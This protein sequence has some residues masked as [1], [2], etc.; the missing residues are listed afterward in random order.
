MG[1]I[2]SSDNKDLSKTLWVVHPDKI[3]DMIHQYIWWWNP[4]DS[5][6]SDDFDKHVVMTTVFARHF[7]VEAWRTRSDAKNHWRQEFE[8]LPEKWPS[9]SDIEQ[10]L[11][12]MVNSYPSSVRRILHD[13]V[14]ETLYQMQ[15]DGAIKSFTRADPNDIRSALK[16]QT[17]LPPELVNIVLE[18]VLNRGQ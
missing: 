16:H 6:S 18:S 8:D 4:Q 10:R 13:G 7:D 17:P 5:L 9:T 2:T 1:G 15:K 12:K 14:V 11:R 3:D